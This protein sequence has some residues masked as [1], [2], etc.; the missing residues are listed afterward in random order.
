MKPNKT[1]PELGKKVHEALIEAG[2]ET[3]MLRHKPLAMQR[4]LIEDLFGHIMSEGLGLDLSDDSLRDTPNRVAKMFV[5][6]VFY[7]LYYENFPKVSTFEN[8]MGYNEM[9]IEKDIQVRSHCEHHFVPI[10]GVAHVAYL[11]EKNVV[12][13]SKINRVVDFFCRRP[14]VQERLTSQ[15]H[16]ALQVILGT[17]NVAIVVE[18]EHFCVKTRGTED[19]CS[20]TTTSKLGGAM[21]TPAARNEFM[22]LI[23]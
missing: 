12:G 14:Q 4:A 21:F 1:D 16:K 11:P 9:I 8:K 3:P 5:D 22:H 17:E 7:G 18:A 10:I 13:L 15:I 23:K 6:E 2:I 19:G 20:S